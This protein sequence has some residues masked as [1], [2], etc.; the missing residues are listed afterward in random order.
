MAATPQRVVITG[1]G[2]VSSLGTGLDV[3]A[4][5]LRAGRSGIQFAP[6]FQEYGLAS[7][8]AGLPERNPTSPLVTRRIEKSSPS[9]ALM[10][11]KATH[12]ALT[13]AGLSAEELRG[14]D[15]AVLIGSG[16]G[17]T[18]QSYIDS[19]TLARTRKV[20]K[21]FPFTVM[22]VMA[23]TCSANVSVALGTRG[24]SWSN[25]SACSTGSHAIGIGALYIKTGRYQR[26]IAG[27]SDGLDWTRAGAF[28]AMY[29][30]SRGYNDRPQEASRP[31]DRG[32]DGFV[33]SG[34]AGVVLLESLDL[35]L[36]RGAPIIAEVLGWGASS[37]GHDMVAP[38]W[39]GAADAMRRGLR[40]A[41]V[42][43]EQVDY[44]NAHGTST[45]PGDISEARAMAEVFG[46]RQPLISSTKSLTGHA[47][48]AAGSLEA[49]Y[50][51]LMMRGRFI[52]PNINLTDRAPEC[53]HLNIV[54]EPRADVDL[55]VVVSNSF[56]FGGTNSVLVLRRWDG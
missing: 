28:D 14:T 21:V 50:S 51:M 47:I 48:G 16:T 8:V 10:A 5:A 56:G 15:V 4:S 53:A 6:E 23:S 30:L 55:R 1:M 41:G 52:A 35:A 22:H 29:A 20:R 9:V 54:A 27:A 34:G 32:R 26:V 44:V 7:Q 38:L 37:D 45:P 11:L 43:A 3:V 40:D 12:E 33:I 19:D 31:F 46:A 36:A 39:E 49:I 25:S 13:T 18:L 42:S 2:A 24:E 17:S